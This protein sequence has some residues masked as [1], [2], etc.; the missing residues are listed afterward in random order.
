M[1]SLPDFGQVPLP[2]VR[3]RSRPNRQSKVHSRPPPRV[4][5]LSHTDTEV[6]IDFI[7]LPR[8]EYREMS[9]SAR[10]AGCLWEFEVRTPGQVGVSV[11]T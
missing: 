2:Q 3:Y 11:R 8:N 5:L 7:D 6:L 1:T 10:V 4:L 9:L